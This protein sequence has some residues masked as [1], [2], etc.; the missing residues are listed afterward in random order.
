M[1]WWWLCGYNVD[2]TLLARIRRHAGLISSFRYAASEGLEGKGIQ[3][4]QRT[5]SR[6][7]PLLRY[8]SKARAF[9]SEE[10]ATVVS[11]LQGLWFAVFKQPFR[12][13]FNNRAESCF[14]M[15]A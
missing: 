13:C 14:V 15:P 10:K 4:C 6:P 3:K 1:C 2:Q 7:D 5:N 8:F 12:L 9:A 11:I